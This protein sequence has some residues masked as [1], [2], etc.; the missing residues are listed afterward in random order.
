[1]CACAHV[2]VSW[3]ESEII[4]VRDIL[5]KRVWPCTLLAT[6]TY[7][8]THP[9]YALSSLSSY[10]HIHTILS[11]SP[12]SFSKIHGS[13]ACGVG[14]GQQSVSASLFGS[15]ARAR[16]S[17]ATPPAEPA[18]IPDP[19]SVYTVR[20]SIWTL[21]G[22]KGRAG[23][24]LSTHGNGRRGKGNSK[25]KIDVTVCARFLPWHPS[26]FCFAGPFFFRLPM[27]LFPATTSFSRSSKAGGK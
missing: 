3:W 12:G 27:V 19:C 11:A 9:P 10:A 18:S 24:G 15:L 1:V 7:T 22:G 25:K 23:G 4:G 13:R 6:P 20:G 26:L 21:K 14:K 17:A 16:A 2:Q 5:A 8:H